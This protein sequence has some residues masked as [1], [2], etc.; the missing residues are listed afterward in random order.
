M[1]EIPAG[2]VHAL[3]DAVRRGDNAAFAELFGEHGV[4]DDWGRVFTGREEV[5][6]WSRRELIGLR[7]TLTV[8]H[9]AASER[10]AVDIATD[11]G[12]NGPGTLTFT[13]ADDG[14]HITRMAMTD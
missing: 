13:L 7:G 8:R 2:P 6:G 3:L 10:L 9:L 1:D 4:V 14:A 12:Y 5:A 11:G